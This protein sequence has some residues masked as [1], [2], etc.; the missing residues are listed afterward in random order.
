MNNKELQIPW[1]EEFR[2]KTLDDVLLPDSVRQKFQEIIEDGADKLNNYLFT[3]V[4]GIGKTT[5]AKVLVKDLG[6]S[7]SMYINASDESGIDVVRSKINT[8]CTSASADGDIKILILDEADGISFQG[9]KALNNIIEK[10]VHVRFIFTCNYPEKI[11]PA[12]KSRLTPIVFKTLS[13][14]E[15]SKRCREILKEKEIKIKGDEQKEN[16]KKLIIKCFPD[17][18]STL[19]LLQ[20]FSRKGLLII[21]FDESITE[22][23]YQTILDHVKDKK[24]SKIR[25]L[26]ITHDIDCDTMLNKFYVDLMLGKDSLGKVDESTRA[27]LLYECCEYIRRSNEAVNKQANFTQFVLELVQNI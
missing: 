20:H 17:M 22:D 5:L 18:R 14:K 25:E 6:I 15:I 1:V 26:L 9:Q 2:P 16:Y 8:F 4:S 27:V 21:E 11:I 13:K 12:I 19:N 10:S 23:F 7:N 24:I 3:G